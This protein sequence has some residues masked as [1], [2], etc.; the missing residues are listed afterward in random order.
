MPIVL[1]IFVS[2]LCILNIFKPLVNWKLTEGLKNKNAEPSDIY[3]LITR[4]SGV[5]V[6]IFVWFFM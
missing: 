5:I 1:K 6:L 2:V 4:I 3:L